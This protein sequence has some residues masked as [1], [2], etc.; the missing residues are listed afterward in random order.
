MTA[1]ARELELEGIESLVSRH[2]A[3]RRVFH[4]EQIGI[5]LRVQTARWSTG[6]AACAARA[7]TAA[8][9]ASGGA[10]S[11]RRTGRSRPRRRL[12]VAAAGT[13]AERANR[14]EPQDSC[15]SHGLAS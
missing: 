13:D 2:D 4:L 8:A 5:V 3:E 9:R 14:D 10:A 1:P 15:R 7:C 6:R 12:V 11:G